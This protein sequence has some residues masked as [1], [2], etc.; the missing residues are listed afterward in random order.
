MPKSLTDDDSVIYLDGSIT[1]G[2]TKNKI[3]GI[4]TPAAKVSR[5]IDSR[6]AYF[7]L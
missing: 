3:D 7:S 4:K 1:K 6:R 2:Q 5:M